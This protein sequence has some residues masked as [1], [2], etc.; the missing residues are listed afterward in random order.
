MA[1]QTLK[2]IEKGR[3]DFYKAM[4]YTLLINGK[5]DVE[6]YVYQSYRDLTS[7]CTPKTG[8]RKK[9]LHISSDGD[10]LKIWPDIKNVLLAG[11]PDKL[12]LTVRLP[13]KLHMGETYGFMMMR[14]K[15]EFRISMSV[16]LDKSFR[17]MALNPF[18]LFSVMKPKL[19]K[20]N[21]REDIWET[22]DEDIGEESLGRHYVLHTDLHGTLAS[23]VDYMLEKINLAM[24]DAEK[25]AWKEAQKKFK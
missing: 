17:S 25:T 3:D 8:R 15:K 1:K 19:S 10:D 12:F 22:L 20:N 18:R 4:T 11:Y 21:I 6:E 5:P 2:L 24:K 23:K 9:N 16:N 7:R 13:R 14:E